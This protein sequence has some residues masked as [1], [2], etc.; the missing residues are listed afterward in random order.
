MI[1]TLKGVGIMS[2]LGLAVKVFI[3]AVVL[4]ICIGVT[5][6]YQPVVGASFALDQLNDNYSS[7]VGVKFWQ[8]FKDTWVYGYILL[9]GLMFMNNIKKLFKK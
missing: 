3:S 1:I 2:K 4:A 7:N 5:T 6:Y 8:T 9:V